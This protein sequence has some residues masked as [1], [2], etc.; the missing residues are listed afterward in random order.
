MNLAARIAVVSVLAVAG[1]FAVIGFGLSLLFE[2]DGFGVPRDT[3]PRAG[4]LLGYG[5]GALLSVVVPAVVAWLLLQRGRRWVLAV[6]A[7]LT[8][9]VLAAL[10]G[11]TV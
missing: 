10:L 9:A 11:V 5:A 1:A 6:A 4:Y 8:V 7:I 2:I 3:P